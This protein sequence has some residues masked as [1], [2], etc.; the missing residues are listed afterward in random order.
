MRNVVNYDQKKSGEKE[1][2]KTPRVEA[3]M[4]KDR[5][6]RETRERC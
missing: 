5:W 3:A 2:G 4:D 6:L 1:N